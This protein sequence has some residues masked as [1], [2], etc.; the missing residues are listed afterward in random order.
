[1]AWLGSAVRQDGKSASLTAPNGPAQRGLL[2]A[3]VADAHATPSMLL[4]VE[5]AASGSAIAD[6]IDAEATVE[7]LECARR[8]DPLNVC[9]AKANACHSEFAS[10]LVG[11]CSLASSLLRHSSPPNATLRILNRLVDTALR[12][13]PCAALTQAVP[14]S[15]AGGAAAWLGVVSSLGY[16]VFV[17]AVLQP[18]SHRAVQ[19]LMN[20]TPCL[21]LI[22]E[23]PMYK[24]KSGREVEAVGIPG[25]LK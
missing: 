2:R 4:R 22:L 12:G 5:S 9:G 24:F 10:G 25:I 21:T 3:A 11:L 16:S 18:P 13:T 14:H 8:S 7:A 15:G 20:G 17:A 1:M 6:P 23:T 19:G